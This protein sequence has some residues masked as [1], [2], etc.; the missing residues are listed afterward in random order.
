MDSTQ[1]LLTVVLTVTTVLLIVVGW[2]LIFLLRDLR[3]LIGKINGIIDAF[4]KVGASLDHGLGELHGFI[5]GFK[6]LTR[7]IDIFHKNRSGRT[8]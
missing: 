4:E 2:Y 1:F 8:K 5:T 6:T 3:K 7:V